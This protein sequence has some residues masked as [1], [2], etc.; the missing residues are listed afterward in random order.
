MSAVS[1]Q[2]V[3]ITVDQLFSTAFGTSRDPRSGE[4]MDGARAVLTYRIDGGRIGQQY[5]VGTTAAD[6]FASCIAGG[7]PS[8]A[9]TAAIR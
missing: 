7:M 9:A 8:G 3:A 5:P 6:A 2:A 1:S 4:Y